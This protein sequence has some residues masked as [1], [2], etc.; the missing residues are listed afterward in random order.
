M[1]E[2]HILK[3]PRSDSQFPTVP[4]VQSQ[5]KSHINKQVVIVEWLC[6]FWQ[7]QTSIGQVSTFRR[8]RA[9]QYKGKMHL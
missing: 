5:P 9:G 3:Q 4:N 2:N 1:I 6:S 7:G 8:V